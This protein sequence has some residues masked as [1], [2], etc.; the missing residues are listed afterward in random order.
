MTVNIQTRHAGT[1]DRRVFSTLDPHIGSDLMRRELVDAAM[2]ARR[3]WVAEHV[4][5]VVGYGVLTKNF[6][7]RNFI[8]LVYVAED[9]RRGGAGSA[10]LSAIERAVTSDRIFTSANE[11]NAPMRALLE[12]RGYKPSGRIDNLDSGNPELI[13]A[14]FL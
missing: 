1:R 12:K 9:A 4:G 14:K 6:F 8:E 3:C 2:A 5:H 11:S 10:L 13:F 7:N